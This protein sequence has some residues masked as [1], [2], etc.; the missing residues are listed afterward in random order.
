MALPVIP[1]GRD[2]V[3]WASLETSDTLVKVDHT[4]GAGEKTKLDN[5]IDSKIGR[6]TARNRGGHRK[7]DSDS[8]VSLTFTRYCGALRY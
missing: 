5:V 2:R 6:E 7:M 8:E 3:T 4:T 1:I